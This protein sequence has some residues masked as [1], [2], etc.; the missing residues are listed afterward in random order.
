[1]AEYDEYTD[2]YDELFNVCEGTTCLEEAFGVDKETSRKAL[3]EWAKEV[4]E[5][6]SQE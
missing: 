4:I 5:R 3:V 2:Y 6:Y 1:M